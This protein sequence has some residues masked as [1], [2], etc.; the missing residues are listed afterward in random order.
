MRRGKVLQYKRWLKKNG[1][2]LVRFPDEAEV[3]LLWSCGFR[4]DVRDS[5]L[6]KVEALAQE[7]PQARIVLGGCLPDIDPDL[8]LSKVPVTLLPWKDEKQGL[9]KIFSGDWSGWENDFP[10]VAEPP[11]CKDAAAYRAE[12][13]GADVQFHDQFIKLLVAEGCGYQCTY[14]SERLAFPPYRSV[15][16]N[17]LT[18]QAKSL[19]AGQEHKSIVLVADSLGQYGQD[20]GITLVDLIDALCALDPELT[21]ALNNLNPADFIRYFDEMKYFIREGKLAHINLP[22]QSGA[23]KILQAMGRT[24]TS[25]DCRRIFAMLQEEGFSRFDTHVIIGFPGEGEEEYRQTLKL[26]LETRPAYVLA[27]QFMS[28]P[29]MV[30]AR[31]P[32]Q[33]PQ[34]VIDARLAD[35][36]QQVAALGIICNVEGGQ[37]MQDRLARLNV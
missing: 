10:I 15:P 2:T 36:F 3:V 12:H 31:L 19:L 20:L 7:N 5:C 23:D 18:E 1:H 28:S 35:F 32:E 21:I 30:A 24:Y 9:E 8:V 33:C 26:I 16:L 34:G 4:R 13:P 37:L 27:S 29:G 22:V 25:A 11:L 17:E 6:A 14:C